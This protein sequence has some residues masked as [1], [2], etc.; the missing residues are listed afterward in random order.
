MI[1]FVACGL[2]TAFWCAAALAGFTG[3][4]VFVPVIGAVEGANGASF[5]STLYVTNPSAEPAQVEISLLPG[6]GAASSPS[7]T[8]SVAPNATRIYEHAATSLFGLRS[9]FGGARIRS[10]QKLLVSARVFERGA[11]EADSK[12]LAFSGVPAGF[13]IPAGEESVLQGVRQTEDY[14]YNVFF[15]ETAGAAVA[16]EVRLVSAEGGEVRSTS[17]LLQPFEQ[18]LLSIQALAAGARIADGTLRIKALS[19]DGRVLAAGSLIAN[20]SND[21]TPFEMAFSTSALVGPPGPPGPAGPQGPA[22][23][24]GPQGPAGPAGPRGPQGLPGSAGPANLLL[25]PGCTSLQLVQGTAPGTG[26]SSGPGYTTTAI[27][28]PGFGVVITFTDLSFTNPTVVATEE[29][30][31]TENLTIRSRTATTV[32]LSIGPTSTADFVAMKCR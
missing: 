11:S 16:F 7:F 4:E 12:G 15:V 17:L 18:R 13:G 14:R 28:G 21:A 8:D 20:A 29:C 27:P 32:T 24:P 3:T 10:S 6:V 25:A 30:F 2:V 26:T 23:P 31:C 9:G 5:D 22:G 19:G 1:R